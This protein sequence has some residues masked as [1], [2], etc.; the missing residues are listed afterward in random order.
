M[1]D[2]ARYFAAQEDTQSENKCDWVTWSSLSPLEILPGLRFQPILGER[3]MVNFVAFDPNTEAPVHWHD[4][5]QISFVI[6]GEFEFEVAGEKKIMKRGDAVVIPPNVP[7]GARTTDT[8]CLEID[9]FV[10]PRRGLLEAMGID[11]P[12]T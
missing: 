12:D 5:E 10:P 7:H 9:V 3:V 6:D 8:S 1:P 2:S 4:E 11:K